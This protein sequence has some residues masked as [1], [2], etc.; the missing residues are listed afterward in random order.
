MN[1]RYDIL[2][3]VNL[4]LLGN[5]QSHSE[6]Y[7]HF[8]DENRDSLKYYE[9]NPETIANEMLYNGLIEKN[10]ENCTLTRKGIETAEN[11]L[12]EKSK[13]EQSEKIINLTEDNL[14]L[15]NWDIRFR[16][17]IAIGT[18]ILGVIIKHIIGK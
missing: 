7:P 13:R 16:W 15:Q 2:I 6:Y 12:Y 18:F 9:I 4:D 11:L 8:I 3:N 14:R 5:K 10:D 1:N 17:Y